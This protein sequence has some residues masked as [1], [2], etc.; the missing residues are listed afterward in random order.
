MSASPQLSKTPGAQPTSERRRHARRPIVD[1]QIVAVTLDGDNGGLV[2]DLA[3]DGLAVQAVAPLQRG[4]TTEVT[5]ALPDGERAIRAQGEVRWAE[6]SGRAGIRLLA[7]LQGS[8]ADLRG[9]LRQRETPPTIPAPEQRPVVALPS[10]DVAVLEQELAAG[11]LE[12]EPALALVA[13]RVR[14]LGSASGVAIALGTREQMICRASAGAAPSV[15][16]RLQSDNGLSGECVRTGLLVRCDDTQSDARVDAEV[17]RQLDLRSAVLVPISDC[18]E[19]RGVLEIFSDRPQAFALDD[20]RGFEQIA[21]LIAGLMREP[22]M[23]TAAAEA[24]PAPV[25]VPAAPKPTPVAAAE[26]PKSMTSELAPA[27]RTAPMVAAPPLASV[28]SPALKYVLAGCGVVALAVASW[29]LLHHRPAAAATVATPV[30][31]TPAPAPAEGPVPSPTEAAVPVAT[32]RHEAPKPARESKPDKPKE[33][34]EQIAL[35]ELPTLPAP[36]DSEPVTP[37][38]MAM[39]TGTLPELAVPSA[40]PARPVT[41]TGVAAGKLVHRVAPVYPDIARRAHIGGLVVL[42]AVIR[43][44]G[45]VGTVE[46]VSGNPLLARAAIEAVKQWR[47]E[48]VRL[49]GTPVQA[50]VSI[51]L[52]FEP[53]LRLRDR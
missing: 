46:V 8:S 43:P 49:N 21:A 19:M 4:K 35:R 50:E 24:P 1:E 47:Y 13:E 37:P 40:Q 12:R 36:S 30:S 53:D 32:A 7:F 16:V 20:I 18:G 22:V 27:P 39:A 44:D 23:E 3:E 45:K 33:A 52:H 15:G 17:C 48:P 38:M 26:R 34:G 9:V 6:P 10:F 28:P 51:R 25:V 42:N 31:A 5:F 29:G 11:G 2:L 41:S 14:E